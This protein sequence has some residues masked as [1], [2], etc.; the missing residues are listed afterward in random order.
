ML[1]NNPTSS[2]LSPRK[3]TRT[4]ILNSDNPNKKRQ[5]LL[6]YFCDTFDLYNKLFEVLSCDESYYRKAIPLRHPL[7][8]YYGHTAAF[9]IN[10]LMAAQLIPERIDT[11]IEAMVAIGV[12]E[13]SWDDLDEKN[14]AWPTVTEMKAYRQKVRHHVCEFI[15]TMP[16]EIPIT[17]ESPA[18]LIMMGIEHERIHLETTSVLIRQLPLSYVKSHPDWQH[19]E[20]YS[21]APENGL[22]EVNGGYQI[23]GKEYSDRLYGWDNE[24]GRHEEQVQ[25]FHASE[26]LFSNQE[27]LTFVQAGDYNTE[28]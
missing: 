1:S 16:L 26:Y 25:P 8:F 3:V 12:D 20:R 11:H 21:E 19:C 23:L 6:D 7:I 15:K 27:F 17:W 18:W 13:M 14:Y 4:L 28:K 24:Y 10:K 22:H 2:P 5:Q 9:F